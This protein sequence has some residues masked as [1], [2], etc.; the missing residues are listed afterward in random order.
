MVGWMEGW[1][2]CQKTLKLGIIFYMPKKIMKVEGKIYI[3][4]KVKIIWIERLMDGWMDGLEDGWMDGW[5]DG[6]FDGGWV[7]GWMECWKTLKLW[8][9][10]YMPKT[11][12]KVDGDGWM[13]GWSVE[14][15]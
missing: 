10:F 9:I 7:D 6:W 4:K 13:D 14:K 8:I 2:E 5:M 1:M 15:H 11:F 3:Q 12:M